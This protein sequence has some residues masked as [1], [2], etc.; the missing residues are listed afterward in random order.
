MFF[1]T[2]I[3]NYKRFFKN[4]YYLHFN[5][6]KQRNNELIKNE[7]AQE[8]FNEK[9]KKYFYYNIKQILKKI[10]LLT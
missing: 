3:F 4:N 2:F 8:S 1:Y 5:L 6:D 10:I 7:I 9:I